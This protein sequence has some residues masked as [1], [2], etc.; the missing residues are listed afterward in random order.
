MIDDMGSVWQPAGTPN[1]TSKF[2]HRTKYLRA[3]LLKTRYSLLYP[4]TQTN[5]HRV[6][7]SFLQVDQFLSSECNDSNG[8]SFLYVEFFFENVMLIR[9]EESSLD[10]LLTTE[11]A[12]L[13]C[14]LGSRHMIMGF[15]RSDFARK[16][17]NLTVFVHEREVKERTEQRHAQDLCTD[18]VIKKKLISKRCR[19]NRILQS[20]WQRWFVY[21]MIKDLSAEAMMQYSLR[22]LFIRQ[23]LSKLC[24][25]LKLPTLTSLQF[26][27]DVW[28]TSKVYVCVSINPQ[29][30][31]SASITSKLE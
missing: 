22:G 26:L 1:D 4:I 2:C 7:V 29:I 27:A 28:R 15:W 24:K 14:E 19:Q 6:R 3:C 30:P 13:T 20:K 11:I 31:F 25:T 12:K 17:R 21:H 9:F 23:F 10:I 8:C 18:F 16:T 5:N